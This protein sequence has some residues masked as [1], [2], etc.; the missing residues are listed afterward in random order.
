MIAGQGHVGLL[1]D[2]GVAGLVGLGGHDDGD[3]GAGHQV[4]GA[5]HARGSLAGDHPVGQ[6]A[7]C[8]DLVSA[9]H[10]AVDVAAADKAEGTEG[11]KAG[12]AHAELAD[13]AAGVDHVG[14]GPLALSGSA[15][16]AN[17]AVLG[18]NPD[19]H[20][21]GQIVQALGGHADAQVYNVAVLEQTGGTVSDQVLTLELHSFFSGHFSAPPIKPRSG[22]GPG[23]LRLRQSRES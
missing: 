23:P 11:I 13:L 7:L 1:H 9:E 16:Q 6:V 14:I 12:A 2:L 5:A 4:H 3:L 22:R 10:G 21:V 8:V 15:G 18:V 20:A 19:I 17:N